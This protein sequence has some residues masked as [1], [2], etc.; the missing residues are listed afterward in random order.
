MIAWTAGRKVAGALMLACLAVLGAALALEHVF[1]VAPCRLCLFQRIPYVV[2]GL[3]AAGVALVRTVP[4][5]IAR[6][7]MLAICLVF[8]AGAGL[9]FYHVG[10][11][12]HWWASAA[13]PAAGAPAFTMAD[14]QR[15]LN[16]TVEIPCDVVRWS[17]FGISLSGY[18]LAASLGLAVLA[19][20]AAARRDWWENGDA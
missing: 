11:E 13:C 12:S 19:G 5:T 16:N 2:A 6:I 3:P 8:L 10:V 18:N 1:G 14:M 20:A 4:A 7:L 17:L 9:A 15:A